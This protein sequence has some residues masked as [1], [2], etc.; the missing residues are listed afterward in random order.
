MNHLSW[1][2]QELAASVWSQA[3]LSVYLSVAALAQ[4]TRS[5]ALS[6]VKLSSESGP[7]I[8]PGTIDMRYR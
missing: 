4:V 7:E 6:E 3:G 2:L 5:H 8:G 1:P